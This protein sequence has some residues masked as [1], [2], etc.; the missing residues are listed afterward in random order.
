MLV[1]FIPFYW[2]I[3][4]CNHHLKWRWSVTITDEGKSRVFWVSRLRAPIIEAVAVHARICSGLAISLVTKTQYRCIQKTPPNPFCPRTSFLES[5]Y[6]TRTT[7][8][9]VL[10]SPFTLTHPLYSVYTDMSL[11]IL[12]TQTWRWHHKGASICWV[13]SVD[14]YKKF[15]TTAHHT[16]TFTVNDVS[17]LQK[18]TYV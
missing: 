16:H 3:L 12:V 18:Q 8:S 1:C 10:I 11:Q 14:S 15:D 4:K 6:N 9:Q 5:R 13:S 7:L 17:L 2:F